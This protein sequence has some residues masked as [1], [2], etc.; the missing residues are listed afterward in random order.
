MNGPVNRVYKKS[1]FVRLLILMLLATAVPFLLSN[2]I[3]YRSTSQSIQG[4]HIQ[5]NQSSMTIGMENLKKYLNEV[6]QLPL[7]W[8]YD[9]DLMDYLLQEKSN[10]AQDINVARQ[11]ASLYSQRPEIRIVHLYAGGSGQKYFQSHY[12]LFDVPWAAT[13]PSGKKEDWQELPGY[14]L[15]RVGN[16]HFFVIHKKLLDH[17]KP[18]WFGLMSIYFSLSEIERLT[19]QMLDLGNEVNFMFFGNNKQLLY[20]SDQGGDSFG[21]RLETIHPGFSSIPEKQGHWFGNWKGQAGVFI[22]V[23]DQFL[24]HPLTII[25]FIPSSSI[26]Q[27]AQQTLKR[28]IAIQFA[29][30]TA[31]IVFTFLLTYSTIAPIKRLLRNMARVETG[32]FGLEGS[33]QR[34]DEIGILEIRFEQMVHNLKEYIIRDYQQR[35]ELSTAQLK[36]L[37]AQINP[38][39]LYNALQSI[40]TLAMRH[41]MEEISDSISELGA[42]LRYSMDFNTEAV[43]LRQEIAYMEHYLSVQEGRFKNK[44]TFCITS[45]PDVLDIH[46]PKMI[47]QP[48]VENSIIHGIEKGIGSGKIGITITAGTALKIS[49]V[50]NGQG[51]D[52]DTVDNLQKRYDKDGLWPYEEGGIGLINVLQR[53]RIKYGDRFEW[54]ITSIPYEKTEIVLSLPI[55]EEVS[56]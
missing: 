45:D 14:E 43:P 9:A 56:E 3:S 50:D 34:E 52:R 35:L 37:Q 26:N 23:N 49:I 15:K 32:N 40:N 51:M 55:T 13:L 30:L 6:N 24:E 28:S 22:Y 19:K 7:S 5:L 39:F 27:T 38:H 12:S 10:V 46:V 36:M 47:L 29:A 17:P 11:I 42:I 21:I 54:T 53:L 2:I 41:K 31:I 16:E 33:N 4:S 48:L 25:K 44:L 8:Y 1:L 20:T 18:V